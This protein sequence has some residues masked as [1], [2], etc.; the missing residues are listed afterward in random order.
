MLALAAARPGGAVVGE[1]DAV[2]ILMDRTDQ[3]VIRMRQGV[4]RFGSS[5]SSVQP[6]VVTVKQGESRSDGPEPEPAVAAHSGVP[7][8]PG[9][10]RAR[11]LT[12]PTPGFMPLLKLFNR[13][14]RRFQ[15][16]VQSPEIVCSIAGNRLTIEHGQAWPNGWKSCE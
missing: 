2:A 8:F 14:N 1:G 5:L 15:G 9:Q 7:A 11:G 12:G 6:C 13:L 4:S 3:E 10:R 16:P